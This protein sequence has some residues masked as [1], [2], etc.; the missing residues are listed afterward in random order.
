MPACRAYGRPRPMP[1]AAL[2]LGL[3]LSLISAYAQAEAGRANIVLIVTDDEDVAAHAFMPKTKALIEDQGTAFEN[4]YI[5]YPWCCPSRASI[6]R[7]QYGH[8][9]HIVGNEPP[10]GGFET[11]RKLGL[12]E[13]TVA[14]WLQ[15]AGYRTAMIG[16]YLNRYVPERDGV[17]PG[18][19]EWYVGGNAH[20]SYDYLLNENGRMVQYG[21][22]P[23]D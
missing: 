5:S 7:G 18:W 2:I 17:P 11:F 9:T 3:C 23:E 13:S 14:T 16:K 10:W 8:N 6:L 15:G 20:E 12:E 1:A 19:N 21:S 4:F 22:G